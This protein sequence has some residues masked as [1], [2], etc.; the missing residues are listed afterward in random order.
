MVSPKARHAGHTQGS[1]RSCVER[2]T[3]DKRPPCP[4]RAQQL[5]LV[6]EPQRRQVGDARLEVQDAA[7]RRSVMRHILGHLRPRPTRLIS[8]KN[9]F[10]SCGNS[11]SFV[12]RRNRPTRVIRG[13]P[14]W[15][16][17][18][19]DGRHS[20]SCSG[21]SKSE[22]RARPTPPAPAGKRPALRRTFHQNREQQQ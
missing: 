6:A 21:I 3:P 22:T 10:Q 7:L 13:S 18:S 12:L 11:S 15:L 5:F 14:S 19:P 17:I 1:A 20:R 8:P 4:S 9:T 2:N 16:P